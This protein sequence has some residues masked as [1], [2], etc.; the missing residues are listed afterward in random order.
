MEP[1]PLDDDEE[2]EYLPGHSR[3]PRWLVALGVVAALIVVTVGGAWWWYQGQID[4]RGGPGDEV[5]VVVPEGSTTSGV[6]DLLAREGIIKNATLFNLSVSED[7]LPSVLAGSYVFRENSSF[8]EAVAVLNAGPDKPATADLDSVNIPEGLTVAQIVAQL[9]EKVPGFEAAELQAALD[10][11]SVPSGLKPQGA[12]SYEGLLFPAT[13]EVAEDETPETFLAKMAAEMESRTSQL[14]IEAAAQ[15]ISQ[16]WGIEVDP[17][18]LLVVASLVQE[19][20]GSP[21]EASKIATVIYNRLRDGTPLGID[22]TSRYLAEL[23]GGE[24]DFDSASPFNTRLQPGLPPTPI[25]T[26]GEYAL[27]A[28]LN[29]ADGPW[30]YYVLTEPGVHTFTD[31]YDEFLEGKAICE[32]ANLGCG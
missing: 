28:A 21:D 22:A 29:P 3:V 9:A 17:Y 23:E 5:T 6:A 24:V 11:G 31:D 13:Y 4:P 14:G 8:D 27:D 32:R 20:A 25:A 2:W 15:S 16:R 19:E 7:E 26:P 30:I 18:D 1:A 10:S 12:T